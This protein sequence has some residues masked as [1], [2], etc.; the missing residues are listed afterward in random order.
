MP[1]RQTHRLRHS[2][3]VAASVA[4][5]PTNV[6]PA[7]AAPA[8]AARSAGDTAQR[9]VQSQASNGRQAA[10]RSAASSRAR[11]AKRRWNSAPKQP[12]GKSLSSVSLADALALA[13][14][15]TGP[16]GTIIYS[17]T[18]TVDLRSSH[19]TRT[20]SQRAEGERWTE[21]GGGRREHYLGRTVDVATGNA[22]ST[23]E[24][25]TSPRLSVVKAGTGKPV[26]GVHCAAS[27]APESNPLVRADQAALSTLPAGPVIGGVAT[28]VGV[29]T[30]GGAS[31]LRNYLD[32]QTGRPL[33]STHGVPGGAPDLETTYLEWDERPAGGSP[34][35]VVPSIG[36]DA[37]L[38]PLTGPK[39]CIEPR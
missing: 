36:T 23:I 29:H 38:S 6:S 19:P 14:P 33:R 5:L 2:L 32:A 20:A 31:E 26:V 17:R 15:F 1:H 7:V 27:T 39:G 37:R 16:T 18:V 35:D 25:W 24:G 11:A 4:A 34:A 30:F 3:V 9:S 8:S 13:P 12:R 21:I 28:R 22:L 10:R